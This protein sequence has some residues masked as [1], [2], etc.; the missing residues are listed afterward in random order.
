MHLPS[1]K[2][3]TPIHH[4]WLIIQLQMMPS[5]TPKLLNLLSTTTVVP[6]LRSRHL[7]GASSFVVRVD[8]TTLHRQP[9]TPGHLPSWI[10]WTNKPSRMWWDMLKR[11]PWTTLSFWKTS[12][13][14]GLDWAWK[15]LGETPVSSSFRRSFWSLAMACYF[16]AS[17]VLEHTKAIT[18]PFRSNP[19]SVIRFYR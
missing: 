2:F 9:K 5:Y 6:S 16:L 1:A 12:K 11:L 3:Q 19:Q 18:Y 10:P 7:R 14:G 4:T 13:V 17:W 8:L 15:Q